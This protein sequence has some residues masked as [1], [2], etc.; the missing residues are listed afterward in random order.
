MINCFYRQGSCIVFNLEDERISEQ[1]ITSL[2]LGDMFMFQNEVLITRSSQQIL[3]F[4]QKINK[5]TGLLEW[6]LY[7][8]FQSK[9]LVSGN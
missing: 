1:K 9:G 7:H 5:N 6:N 2:D 4:R 3:F 8:N